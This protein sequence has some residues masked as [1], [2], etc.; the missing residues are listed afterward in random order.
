MSLLSEKE[1]SCPYCGSDNSVSLDGTEGRQYKLVVDCEV[2]CRPIIIRVQ[3]VD[4][5]FELDVRPENE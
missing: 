2:C 3:V 1:F 5:E 4:R